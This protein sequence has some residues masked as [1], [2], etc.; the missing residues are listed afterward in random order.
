[1]P[2]L[3]SF[4][5]YTTRCCHGS[6]AADSAHSHKNCLFERYSLLVAPAQSLTKPAPRA[7]KEIKICTH[8]RK[9][10]WWKFRDIQT[11]V[12]IPL[13]IPPHL[14]RPL[15]KMNPLSSEAR[16]RA[17]IR[18]L[19]DDGNLTCA[20]N[21]ANFTFV[22]LNWKS[23]SEMHSYNAPNIT[24]HRHHII[25]IPSRHSCQ[26]NGSFVRLTPPNLT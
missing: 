18:L 19:L 7:W 6:W 11:V 20:W 9:Y 5:H 15:Q 3:F 16:T 1:M 8:V 12:K 25:F 2:C 14:T 22:S 26:K 13:S 24:I 23:H 10:I 17:L 21:H 4:P